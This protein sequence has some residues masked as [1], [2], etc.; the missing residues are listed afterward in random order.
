MREDD[1]AA[2]LSSVTRN[3][4]A[5]DHCALSGTELH[6]GDPIT[7]TCRTDGD[8][9]TNGED[10]NARDD[11]N[12]GLAESTLWY[13]VR[14]TDGRFGYLSAIW[15]QPQQRGGLGLPAC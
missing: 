2:Y 9:T 14:R 6:S 5:D 15:V 12:P 4:C 7:A 13:G 1:S 8:R 10:R 3:H 11:G